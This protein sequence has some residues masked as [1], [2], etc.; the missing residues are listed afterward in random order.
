MCYTMSLP[1]SI[2]LDLI[3]IGRRRFFTGPVPDLGRPIK[4]YLMNNLCYGVKPRSD[5]MARTSGGFCPVVGH[6]GLH[7][8][9]RVIGFCFGH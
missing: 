5:P 4:N 1:V 7:N 9:I 2:H 8:L 3:R 6:Q